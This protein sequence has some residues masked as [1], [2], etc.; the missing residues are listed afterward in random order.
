MSQKMRSANTTGHLSAREQY[1]L[2]HLVRKFGVHARLAKAGRAVQ[3]ETRH[4]A[5][6]HGGTVKKTGT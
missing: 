3:G 1:E 6:E 2:D 5:D 4:D